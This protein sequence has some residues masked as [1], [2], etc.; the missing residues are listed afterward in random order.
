MNIVDVAAIAPYYLTLFL[1]PADQFGP[2]DGSVTQETCGQKG[3]SQF[4]NVGRVMQ[5]FT[6]QTSPKQRIENQSDLVLMKNCS[7]ACRCSVSRGS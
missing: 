6:V 2:L 1:F 3:E 5:V 4:G 7:P